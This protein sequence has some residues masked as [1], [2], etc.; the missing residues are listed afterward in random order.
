MSE[1]EGPGMSYGKLPQSRSRLLLLLLAFVSICAAAAPSKAITVNQV[2]DFQDDTTQ[3]WSGADPTQ[4]PD[5]GPSGTGD[6]ALHVTATGSDSRGGKLLAFNQEFQWNGNWTA[7][8]VARIAMDVRNPNQ[9]PLAMRVGIS[10]PGR[11]TFNGTG[12]VHVSTNPIL[13]PADNSWH[14]VV[15]PVLAADFTSLNPQSDITAALAEVTHLRILHNLAVQF[16]GAQVSGSFYVDNIRALALPGDYDQND[17]VDAADYVVWRKNDGSP[18]GYGMWRNNFG[19]STANGAQFH[20]SGLAIS[21]VPE[22]G[23]L[24]LLLSTMA[25]LSAAVSRC[26]ESAN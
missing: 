24:L 16:V 13:I 1:L 7:A 10:G 8:G 26:R 14:S 11:F 12:D 25:S 21:S 22:P 6:F 23:A 5:S 18:G 20:A 4:I 15:F 3:H 9:F 19:R 2:D 17:A